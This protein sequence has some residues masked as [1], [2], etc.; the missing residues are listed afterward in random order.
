MSKNLAKK[1]I[2]ITTMLVM[3]FSM[4]GMQTSATYAGEGI[5]KKN[6]T[7]V[8]LA[9]SGLVK[10]KK[11]LRLAKSNTVSEV[12]P[13]YYTEPIENATK[14]VE[15]KTKIVD[16][17]TNA[18]ENAKMELEKAKAK[19]TEVE[20][21]IGVFP[22]IKF[23]DPAAVKNYIEG[24]N[25]NWFTDVGSAENRAYMDSASAKAARQDIINAFKNAKYT[26]TEVDKTTEVDAWNMTNAQINE[27]TLFGNSIINSMNKQFGYKLVKTN[28][29]LADATK[30]MQNEYKRRFVTGSEE[31]EFNHIGIEDD[32]TKNNGKYSLGYETLCA[33]SSRTGIGGNMYG[34][35]LGEGKYAMADMKRAIF[36]SIKAYMANGNELAHAQITTS[37]DMI[38]GQVGVWTIVPGSTTKMGVT[39]VQFNYAFDKHTSGAIATGSYVDN[40]DKYADE[41]STAKTTVELKAAAVKEAVKTLEI[42]KSEL[43]EAEQKLSELK[44]LKA[45]AEKEKKD[46]E[47]AAAVDN[48]IDKI[49]KVSLASEATIRE[50]RKAFDAL[51]K[52]QQDRVK[53]KDVLVNAEN[54]LAEL[55]AALPDRL[56][57]ANRYETAYAVA[58]Q[59]K[60]NKGVSKFEN[61]VVA[62]GDNYPDAL[63]G[64]YLAKVKNAPMLL[65]NK[66][67]IKTT[68][69]YIKRNLK[70]GGTVYILGGTSAIPDSL[71]LALDGI[72]VKR[73]GG[74]TRYETNELIL[75]EAGVSNEELLVCS[76]LNFP[77]AVSASASGRPILLVDKELNKAQ[78]SYLATI[79]PK[80]VFFIGGEAVISKSVFNKIKG[81]KERIFGSNRFE[82]SKAIAE[83]LFK[84]PIGN[85]IIASG[86]DFP[87]ALVGGALNQDMGVPILLVG[88]GKED[89]DSAKA[90]VEDNKIMNLTVLGGR[91][92]ISQAMVDKIL[93]KR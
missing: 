66:Y 12:D 30:W 81:E 56:E 47:A 48:K 40:V 9:E 14:L 25:F 58:E 76:G 5:S 71:K 69:E 45:K 28:D 16:E 73:L 55:K 34:S 22:E 75:K 20:N 77:D 29:S 10:T 1:G 19:Q 50:V 35:A 64:N 43:K 61:I 13:D 36:E 42:A 33:G 49:G 37:K 63:S 17:K 39:V 62:S 15:K 21:K 32:Y 7:S 53:K 51:T 38:E 8:D 18:V 60:K 70:A 89:C 23:A 65:T 24:Y 54:K 6:E 27:L 4:L 68:T 90:F 78:E 80:K 67:E 93:K 88:D 87:D 46:K 82:T 57:G 91:N 72:N 83:K 31:Y 79:N 85:V 3:L 26:P 84:K 59:I 2:A 86:L 41:L 52:E 44:S 74:T 92:V 11:L